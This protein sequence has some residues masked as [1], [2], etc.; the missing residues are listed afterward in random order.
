[1][2]A[3]AI[4]LAIALLHGATAGN[5]VT[6]S[7]NSD[8]HHHKLIVQKVACGSGATNS[9]SCV[10]PFPLLEK[11][12]PVDWWFV[13]KLNAA[14]FPKCGV[15]KEIRACP[16]GGTVQ[17]YSGFG[18]QFVLASSDNPSLKDGVKDCVGDTTADP[19]GATFDEIY[20]GRFHFVIWNDQTYQDPEI[21]GCSGDSCSAP[22]GHSKGLLAWNDDG[23]GLVMQVTTPSWPGAGSA[24]FPRGTDG[25]TLGC[26][27]DNNVKSS[28]H[29]FSL[30]LDKDDVVEVLKG[31]VNASVV[32]DPENPQ[33]VN[34]GGPKEIQQL[35]NDLGKKS[36]SETLVIGKLST[37][38]E[39]IAKP[40]DLNVP[41]W[42][43][44]SS[45]LGGVSLRTATWWMNPAIY[46]TTGDAT[47]DCWD[48]SL[49]DPG[50]VEIATSGQWEEATFS[51]KG[52]G[53]S[54]GNHAKFGV[55]TSGNSHYVI[56]GDMNQQGTLSPKDTSSKSGCASSQNGRGGLFFVLEDTKLWTDLGAL[57]KGE[58]AP[59]SP[60][61]K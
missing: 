56:F 52:G 60:P 43:M 23:A 1:M 40:S 50:A 53:G 18:Q 17:D 46:S 10:A 8:G 20:N 44:V 22:W 16:F 41:P 35:V 47:P 9:P 32:T 29:F 34:N 7:S 55:S 30:R 28:Q 3:P 31:L 36:S 12:H 4:P 61:S 58:T 51:L 57:I 38:V 5:P 48:E 14:K 42:Q 37:G 27:K 59:T 54:N 39:L 49:D 33:F 25:N 45:A 21:D 24:K 13:F 19:V 15:E 26:V 6:R 2:L 11:G